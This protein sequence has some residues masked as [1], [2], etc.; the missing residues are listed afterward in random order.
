MTQIDLA[1]RAR[2]DGVK[3][4]LAMFVDLAG[5]PCAKL[6]PVE[7]VDILVAEGVGFAGYAVGLMGQQPS[8]PDLMAMPDAASYTPLPAIREGLALV[9]CDPHVEG[10]P[11]PFAPRV[12]LK[13][14]LAQAKA[15]NLELLRRGGARVLPG[16]AQRRT[17]PSAS[18]TPRTTRSSPATTRAG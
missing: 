3:F 7:A 18:P 16:Q 17:G 1:A 12:I 14:L 5:K 13:T 2:E 11:W 8:D 9:H 15:Q 6:V 10:K 4:I